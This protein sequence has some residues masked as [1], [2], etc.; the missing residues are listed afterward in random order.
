MMLFLL[1]KFSYLHIF[2]AVSKVAYLTVIIS[3][4]LRKQIFKIQ[5]YLYFS[6][7]REPLALSY[8]G[9]ADVE[10]LRLENKM[11]AGELR[12]FR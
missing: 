4:C 8:Q 1:F 7:A 11:I 2:V 12:G 6:D 9:F 5:L 3:I 10:Y